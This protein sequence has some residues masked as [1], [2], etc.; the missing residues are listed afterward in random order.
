MS[1]TERSIIGSTDIGQGFIIDQL[2]NDRGD[3]YYRVCKGG[4]CRFCEDGY[5]AYMYAESMGWNRFID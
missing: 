4:V 5:F 3:I 2:E 1:M